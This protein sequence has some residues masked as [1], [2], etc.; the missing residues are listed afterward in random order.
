MRIFVSNL[1]VL[2]ARH[3]SFL[4]LFG[5]LAFPGRAARAAITLTLDL[6]DG[7]RV[8]DV[9]KVVAHADSGDGIDKVEFRVDDQL[10]LTGVSV[11]Y[12]FNW[13][14]IPETEGAHKL[15]I[16][17][18]DGK[19]QTKRVMLS[20][21][22]DNELGLGA[23]TL[24]QKA[25]EALDAKNPD[26]AL[27]YGR[28]TLKA[29]PNHLEGARV[30]ASVYAYSGDWDRAIATL[31]KRDLG[32]NARAMLELASYRMRR[33]LI[34]ENAAT[35]F[36]ELQAINDLRHKAAN[37]AVAD[38]IKR[39]N[40]PGGEVTLQGHEAIGDAL[41]NAGRYAEAEVEYG[42]AGRGEDTPLTSLNRR[43]LALVMATR[44]EEALPLVRPLIRSNKGDAAT[45]AVYGLAMLNQSHFEE[46]RAA[47]QPDLAADHPAA[48]LIAS[49]ADIALGKPNEALREAQAAAK[50]LPRAGETHFAL[51]LTAI[52]SDDSEQELHRTL[53]LTPFATGPYLELAAR[54]ALRRTSDRFDRAL[55][56]VDLVRAQEPDNFNAR[57]TQ[58][59]ILMAANRLK[60][61]E[62][63]LDMFA[64]G[65]QKN[66]PD[67]LM[68]LSVY[69]QLKGQQTKANVLMEGA[70]KLDPLR[71]NFT[72]VPSPLEFLATTNHKYHYRGGFFMLPSTLYPAKA[73]GPTGDRL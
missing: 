44:I 29:D 7:D 8:S 35:F 24:A 43:A 21:T 61:A 39:Y 36:T 1:P 18:F 49:Y 15:V 13:D 37:I 47:V 3:L 12:I 38:T 45:R 66:T 6:K 32:Q 14:T 5:L 64:R 48:L 9:A 23:D 59:L 70:R 16:T 51:A 60:E 55:K 19:G 25:Q 71:I 30:L 26:M 73:D 58:V 65:D 50:L 54:T 67:V 31:D 41:M 53:A 56:F 17:A 2:R 34:P 72:L 27:N 11:P 33:A 10:R 57:I 4:L 28:R 68:A 40:A 62:P 22:V 46:A 20:L 42:K 69:W 63:I 52:R